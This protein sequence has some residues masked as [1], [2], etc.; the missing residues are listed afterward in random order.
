MVTLKDVMPLAPQLD[1]AGFLCRDPSL[2]A[3]ASNVLY[4]GLDMDYPSFPKE[5][6]LLSYPKK[7]KMDSAA[8]KHLVSFGNKLK[9]FLSGTTKHYDIAKDFKKNTPSNS[10]TN[11]INELLSTTYPILISQEQIRLVRNPFYADY[12]A[13]YQ[14]RLPFVDPVPLIRWA[15]GDSFPSSATQDALKNKT[16]FADWFNSHVLGPDPKSCSDKILLYVGSEGDPVYRNVY[17]SAPG[18]PIGFSSGRISPFSGAPDFVLPVGQSAYSSTI[19]NHTEK[20]P[21]T[22]DIMAARHCDGMLFKLINALVAA[23]ILDPSVTGRTLVNGKP[24]LFR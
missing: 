2:W 18:P 24:I 22:V 17:R 12:A 11:D 13:K 23:E 10:P 15:Y 19:T 8:E 14:G 9:G 16:I 5:I 7:G 21:D 3:D 6:L 20:L 4:G 1:T